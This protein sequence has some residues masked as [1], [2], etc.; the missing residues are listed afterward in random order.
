M[1]G[2]RERYAEV[3]LHIVY[4]EIKLIQLV[5]SYRLVFTCIVY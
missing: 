2:N 4:L 1:L 5:Q 3:S